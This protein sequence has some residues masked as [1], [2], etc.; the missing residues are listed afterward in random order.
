[1]SVDS[2][3]QLRWAWMHSTRLLCR[4][5][6]QVD[7]GELGSTQT[8]GCPSFVLWKLRP[9]PSL[10][11]CFPLTPGLFTLAVYISV[12]ILGYWPI[13]WQSAKHCAYARVQRKP[14]LQRAQECTQS[15]PLRPAGISP[16]VSLLP[17]SSSLLIQSL[18]NLHGLPSP[19]T[20]R[21]CRL[22]PAAFC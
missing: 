12:Y 4:A 11:M 10:E 19:L 1:M 20:K 14:P 8:R 6:S 15:K 3:A 17:C 5:H 2:C 16:T 13:K 18:L 9:C 21:P 22:C 7:A